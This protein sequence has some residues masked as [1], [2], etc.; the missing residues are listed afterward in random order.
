MAHLVSN[1]GCLRSDTAGGTI[2]LVSSVR[3]RGEEVNSGRRARGEGTL[4][5]QT[6]GRLFKLITARSKAR[7][8]HEASDIMPAIISRVFSIVKSPEIEMYGNQQRRKRPIVP[9]RYADKT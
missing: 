6:N 3:Y 4:T 7:F 5:C 8:F 2:N 9:Y 1:V